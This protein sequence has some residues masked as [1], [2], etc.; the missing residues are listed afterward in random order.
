MKLLLICER[1][2]IG[3]Y[4]SNSYAIGQYMNIIAFI[5]KN[6]LP[7]GFKSVLYGTVIKGKL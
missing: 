1:N 3:C 7:D 4:F 2:S 6:V 5:L